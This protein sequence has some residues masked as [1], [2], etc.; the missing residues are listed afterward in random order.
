MR[1]PEAEPSLSA[2]RA[3]IEL[4]GLRRGRRSVRLCR[5]ECVRVCVWGA[6]DLLE[7]SNVPLFFFAPFPRR[8]KEMAG[9]SFS[10]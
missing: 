7:L 9:L 6:S 1:R 3:E 8:N 5:E 2:G 10:G 4:E